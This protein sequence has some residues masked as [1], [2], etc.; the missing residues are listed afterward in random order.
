VNRRLSSRGLSNTR[1]RSICDDIPWVHV[2]STGKLI[3]R[4][5][6]T[7]VSTIWGYLIGGDSTY[8]FLRRFVFCWLIFR[9]CCLHFFKIIVNR[10]NEKRKKKYGNMFSKSLTSNLIKR[11]F[12]TKLNRTTTTRW[13]KHPI[14]CFIH[15]LFVHFTWY[16]V[17]LTWYVWSG[18]FGISRFSA[19][20]Y[21]T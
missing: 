5:W 3:T 17:S 11:F 16:N 12:P 6:K 4:Y 21:V 14:P 1:R 10:Q 2:G 20:Q 8:I 9:Y 15:C 18:Y 13:L 19:K 7:K